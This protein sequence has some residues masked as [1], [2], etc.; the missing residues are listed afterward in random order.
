VPTPERPINWHL[1]L[2]F[3]VSLMA[4]VATLPLWRPGLASAPV[5]RLLA[6]AAA[7]QGDALIMGLGL[8]IIAAEIAARTLYTAVFEPVVGKTEVAWLFRATLQ[9]APWFVLG[10]AAYVEPRLYE[11]LHRV[12]WPAIAVAVAMKAAW[13]WGGGALSGPAATIAQAA[14]EEMATMAAATALL[15]RR[16]L[17]GPRDWVTSMND[18]VYTVYLFHFL[19][20][21][22]L[23]TT[24]LPDTLPVHLRLGLVALGAFA[25][26]LALHRGAIARVPALA[27]LFNGRTRLR[28]L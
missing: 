13:V 9:Y 28:A 20:I 1:H 14:A 12:S 25:L 5:R 27:L 19:I 26:G 15:A 18:A 3:L 7:R 22:V 2:W 23:A 11:A 24:I 10:A 16:W 4:Y 6:C 8:A 17:S 21:Y